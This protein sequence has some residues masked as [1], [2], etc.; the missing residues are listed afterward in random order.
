MIDLRD[1]AI[2]QELV[3]LGGIALNHVEIRNA[4]EPGLEPAAERRVEFDHDETW[5][6]AST[7]L[8]ISAV[9]GPVPAPSSTM[10]LA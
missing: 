1:A 2:G 8:T 7:R 6:A 9:I 4:L 10:H 5:C 3:E